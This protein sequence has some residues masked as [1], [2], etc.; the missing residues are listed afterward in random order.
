MVTSR[1]VAAAAGVS[2]ATV[3]RVISESTAVTERTR[4]R[5]LA[6]MESTG[7]QPDHAARAMRT[8]RS[9]TIGIVVADV[10]NPF[11]P[12]VIAATSRELSRRGQRMILWESEFGGDL[13][14]STAVGQRQVDGM[15]FTTALPDSAPLRAAMSSGR[16][17]V[18]M[19]RTIPGLPCDQVESDN[20]A[21]SFAVARYFAAH[22]H[23]SV[24]LLT[25][26]PR[27][28]TAALREQG[29]RDGAAASGMRLAASHVVDGAFSH[30]GGYRALT[31]LMAARVRPTAVFCVNDVSALGALDA[32]LA[33][34]ISVPVDLWV[35]GYDDIDMASWE[36][37]SL[38]TARQPIEAMVR[39]AIDLLIARISDPDRPFQ[40]FQFPGA[41]KV[42][43]STSHCALDSPG[44]P[45][46]NR[47]D[48]LDC[49]EVS[50]T[51]I[52]AQGDG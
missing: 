1:D 15:I 33:L 43:G 41:L 17:T 29:F 23:R 31:A 4:Q 38:T 45:A 20:Y 10:R 30:A 36:A 13:G 8:G 50:S 3:S 7:Y 35:A 16:P 34:G 9:G 44:A 46:V 28:S 6:A 39:K 11:Y 5:V 2:Q 12:E 49:V 19:N 27:A 25:A 52:F 14:A 18:L 37:F 32:A 26:D 51:G 24:G 48:D 40:H 42:R 47:S 22:G 21:M